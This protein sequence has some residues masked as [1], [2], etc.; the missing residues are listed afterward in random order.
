[1]NTNILRCY[2]HKP[3]CKLITFHSQCD[4]LLIWSCF[5]L[6]VVTDCLLWNICST[7]GSEYLDRGP[8][9]PG[10]P[11]K[12]NM[13]NQCSKHSTKSTVLTSV[14]KA[15]T[16]MTCAHT[17]CM[18]IV[19]VVVIPVI[20]FMQ[21]MYNYTPETKYVS[22]VYCVTAVPYLQFV[23]HVMLFHLWNTLLLLLLLLPPSSSSSLNTWGTQ[24]YELK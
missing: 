1:M 15:Y 8:D 2:L 21:G 4:V 5:T 12:R 23:L 6:T 24:E 19:V 7:W 22:G 18:I 10:F 16:L 17:I 20:T 11:R 13:K 9:I 3:K 14:F